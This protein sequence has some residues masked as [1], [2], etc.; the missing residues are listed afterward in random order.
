MSLNFYKEMYAAQIKRNEHFT[1][2]LRLTISV[3]VIL[4]SA[5]G[6]VMPKISISNQ[7]LE[8]NTFIG[9]IFVLGCSL[10]AFALIYL[11]KAYRAPQLVDMAPL[12]MWLEHEN[13]LK[14]KL[15]QI[16]SVSVSKVF[17]N[18]LCIEFASVSTTNQAA[19]DEIG[20]ALEKSNKLLLYAFLLILPSLLLVQFSTKQEVKIEP[21]KDCN[22]VHK[23]STPWPSA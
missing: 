4:G 11:I 7:L 22:H 19:N 16:K 23:Y 2:E 15:T 1:N 21:T 20:T 17:E 12:N 18:D 3:M 14:K 8:L 10:Y 13:E 9:C 5:L 6:Y